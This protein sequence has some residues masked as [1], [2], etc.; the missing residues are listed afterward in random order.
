MKD[1]PKKP[2]DFAMILENA[3]GEKKQ[4]YFENPSIEDS[5]AIL[6]EL[7]TF[8]HAIKNQDEPIVSL[9]NGTDALDLAYQ[10][11]EAYS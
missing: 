3:D 8:A 9:K 6:E 1:V 5:N 7:V 10:V 11:I 4:I 2:E